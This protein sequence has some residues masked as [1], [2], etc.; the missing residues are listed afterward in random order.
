MVCEQWLESLLVDNNNT[1]C[2]EY[3]VSRCWVEGSTIRAVLCGLAMY[4]VCDD[5]LWPFSVGG[6]TR[7]S[8]HDG[9]TPCEF[10]LDIEHQIIG[11][12]LSVASVLSETVP[13][14]S[15]PTPLTSVSG[16]CLV[17]SLVPLSPAFW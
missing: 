10:S 12:C 17:E 2:V 13:P 16:A 8:D 5:V 4:P 1:F 9:G 14:T 7:S 11:C 3:V 6:L 15:R